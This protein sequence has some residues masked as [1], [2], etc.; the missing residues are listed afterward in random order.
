MISEREKYE[1][2]EN[3]LKGALNNESKAALE[4]SLRKDPELSRQLEEYR[5]AHRLIFEGGLLDLR[6]ELGTL[7]TARLKRSRNWRNGRNILFP[8]GI[9][10]TGIMLYVLLNRNGDTE[11]EK[12]N[13]SESVAGVDITT[14]KVVTESGEKKLQGTSGENTAVPEST[15]D[16][17]SLKTDGSASKSMRADGDKFMQELVKTK[18]IITHEK[19]KET[20]TLD[21]FM[22]DKNNRP[23]SEPQ[24]SDTVDEAINVPCENVLIS[25]EFVAENTCLNRSQGRIMFLSQS[26]RGGKPPYEFSITGGSAFESLLLFDNLQGGRYYLVVR[27]GDHCLSETGI[28]EIGE[29]ECDFRFAPDKGEVWEIP[30]L[31]DKEGKLLIFSK[32]GSIRYNAN[33][34]ASSNR[35][36]DGRTLNGEPLPLGVYLFRIE[37]NDGSLFNGTVTIIK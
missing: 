22:T 31:N 18:A 34:G 12:K 17:V 23:E 33:V 24:V 27:D 1:Q 20:M 30:I 15:A 10:V 35:E 25:F 14:E 19:N 9:I 13:L 36:W 26:V 32:E 28:A 6:K 7:H 8:A 29:I 3:Y 21:M 16:S 2:F 37:F 4:E 5:Q 11:Q